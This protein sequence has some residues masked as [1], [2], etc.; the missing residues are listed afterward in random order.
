MNARFFEA[1]EEGKIQC[2][3]CPHNCLIASGRFGACRV[4]QNREGKLELPF[5]GRL[6]AVASDP[7]EKK[8]LYHFYPGRK[9]L[10]IG[11]VG[12]SFHCP[13]CQNHHI[14]HDTSYPTEFLSPENLLDL[15]RQHG[16]FGV[17]YTYSE[18]I[19]HLEY[20]LDTATLVRE[21]GLKNVLVS[22]GYINPNPAE[23][24]LE[25]MDAANID[26]KSWNP[27]FYRKEI[28]GKVEEVKRFLKQAY[29]K[30]TLEVTTLVI[31]TKNDSPEEIESI[32]GFLA[33]LSPDI[34]YHLSAY[35]P[36][37]RYKIPPT[38]PATLHR[39]AEAARKHLN[40]VYL[41][42]V[43][44]EETNTPCPSCGNLLIRRRGYSVSVRG[45]EDGR[46]RDCGAET[47]ITGV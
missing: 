44:S 4:R 38:P 13:F 18:P 37:Y 7:I 30:I 11:F 29:D 32:A 14:A 17:S 22:N 26:F 20:V 6:S 23:Q 31:P 21:Q 45:I 41:G 35:Y 3:L 24:L 40:Y 5:Y 8:P 10:S 16:S 42:N 28:G 1:A 2:Q 15:C 33:A 46:C 47:S 39:L 27:E 9:I 34:P 43:G 12:C 36:Q 25:F 19:V